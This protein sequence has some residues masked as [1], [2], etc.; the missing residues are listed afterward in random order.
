MKATV[1][2]VHVCYSYNEYSRQTHTVT[3]KEVTCYKQV[4]THAIGALGHINLAVLGFEGEVISIANCNR[5]TH[6]K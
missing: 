5:K 4:E 1:S 2:I 3:V 6:K